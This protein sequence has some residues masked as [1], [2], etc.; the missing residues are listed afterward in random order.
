MSQRPSLVPQAVVFELFLGLLG[1]VV[2]LTLDHPLRSRLLASQESVLRGVA[3]CVPMIVMLV[4]L[5]RS[6]WGPL[7]RLRKQV[8]EVVANLFGEASVAAL[9][10]VSLA[11]G[12]GEEILFRGALQPLASSWASPLV[13][14]IAVSLL[15][16][17]MHAASPAYFVLATLVG[18]Y[19][20]WLAQRFDDLV[21][22]I[23]AHWLY[24]WAALLYLRNTDS[25]GRKISD[26]SVGAHDDSQNA[27]SNSES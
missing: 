5:G 27:N 23:I 10:A 7:A 1:A 17:L 24:D 16:G 22:P 19:F 21:A 15:F 4:L 12:V 8:E 25:S 18:L 11:A 26:Q 13:G 3:A 9:A 6:R 20:G 2:A 14:L